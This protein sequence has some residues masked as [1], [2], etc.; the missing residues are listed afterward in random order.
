M[1]GGSV[2]AFRLGDIGNYTD[3]ADLY[4]IGIASLFGINL[5]IA[6]ARFGNIGGISLNTYFDTFG[7]EGIMANLALIMIVFQITRWIYTVGY[8]STGSKAW[9]P[10]I[11]ICILVAAQFIHD[12]IFYYGAINVVPS[13]VNEML[14]VLKQ[15]SAQNGKNV[16]GGHTILMTLIGFM[17]MVFKEVSVIFRICLIFGIFYAMPYLITM[18]RY[19]PVPEVKVEP[20]AEPRQETRPDIRQET[21]PQQRP[22]QRK[23]P[24]PMNELDAFYSML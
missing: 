19:R 7:L 23:E 24:Q 5:A 8:N 21:R 2:E 4:P 12:I 9:S 11:F 6:G 3:V 15:Y 22:E 13:H 20:K 10:F 18:V 17:A 1:E 16:I 14:D